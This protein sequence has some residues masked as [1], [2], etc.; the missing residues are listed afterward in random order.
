MRKLGFLRPYEDN[1]LERISLIERLYPS[2]H[3]WETYLA[4]RKELLKA[5]LPF[6]SSEISLHLGGSSLFQHL[7]IECGE[8]DG[9]VLGSWTKINES[10]SEHAPDETD[11]VAGYWAAAAVW[12]NA[13]DQRT[14]DH[15]V[16]DQ[17]LVMGVH[18]PWDSQLEYY[19]CHNDWDEV[20]KLLDLIPED[21]LYDGSLQIALDGPKQSSGVNYSVSSR[22][23]YICSIEEVDAVLMDVPYIKI[24]R[25]PGDI[26][27]S[28]WLTTLMEQELARKLIFLKEYWENALDVVYLL[29]RAGVILGNCEVSFKEETCTPSLDLCLSIKKGGANV[30][31]LNA[32][33][34]LFIHYCTQYNL[35]NLLDLY[36]DHH[37]L[38]L[39]ND[40]LSSLQEAVGDSHW[41]KWLLLSRIKG[42]EYDASF[43]NARSIMSRNGAPN[44]EPSVPEID[45]M[46][47]TV[48]DIADGAGEMAALATMMCAPV[49]IQKS[50][51][52][53][54]VNR[55]TNSSAQCTLEN[56]RSFLQRFPTLWSKLVSACLGEDI[57]GNLLRTKTKNVLSEYLNWRDGVFFS[58]ARDTSLLQMLPCWFPK[59][60]RRL[61]QLYI[62]GPLGWLSFS[63]YP[64]GEYLLH[65]G[66]E[67][68]I[69]VDDPT[70]I[71][72]ISWEA[73]IQK[74]IEEELHHTKTEV[75]LSIDHIPI[76]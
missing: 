13:W 18:V 29:A 49:P 63:G 70:E 4:R 57:S 31:T 59:A 48:D 20:L 75:T 65:R 26:R 53:G 23:E 11:A 7:K 36:L 21:V 72:A 3:F 52:T 46:V 47:C 22:S 69:N 1:V 10:A 6:D 30:D 71:S 8:V 24:F 60:V 33:H 76:L 40:S 25:L 44:S 15:I 54:S 14:F 38:V 74:H 58:T 35:P 16:L 17:P 68:F 9:V 37:E 50:L 39:D 12:S 5:A 2:S 73:I 19:M 67:F 32:V 64:T 28:L 34:K 56:L 27:C 51:S 66:V 43:S 42:R 62:Q 55:H 61:V 45:E 41:A